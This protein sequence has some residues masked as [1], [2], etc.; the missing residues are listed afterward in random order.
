MNNQTSLSDITDQEFDDSY[1]ALR[2]K[3]YHRLYQIICFILFLGPIRILFAFGTVLCVL[4]IAFIRWIGEKFHWEPDTG[5]GLCLK[6]YGISG[7]FLNLACGHIWV[8]VN[9]FAAPEAR[10]ICGNHNSFVDAFLVH[11]FCLCR[12]S[13]KN[14]YSKVTIF[15]LFF[16]ITDCIWIDR[17]TRGGV[18]QQF[19][20]SINDPTK[21]PLVVFPEG[22]MTNGNVLLKFHTGAFLTKKPIQP[23]T[24]RYWQTFVRKGWNTNAYTEPNFL[25]YAFGL[26]ALP[27][28]IVTVKL[29]PVIYPKDDESPEELATRVQ[30]AIANDLKVKAVSRSSSEIFAARKRSS[31]SHP[32]DDRPKTE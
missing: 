6:I 26:L 31:G 24:I 4:L 5:R 7:R 20:D 10:V 28:S 16:G 23:F 32:V 8:Q 17:T 1:K 22:T 25:L 2:F 27:P 3:W 11:R 19:K 29:L 13:G 12:S 14:D 21:R 15:R 9:K 30:L 18:S